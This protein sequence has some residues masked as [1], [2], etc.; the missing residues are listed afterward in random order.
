[1]WVIVFTQVPIVLL[2]SIAIHSLYSIYEYQT[3]TNRS[4]LRFVTVNT[5]IDIGCYTL[6]SIVCR[7]LAMVVYKLQWGYT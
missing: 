1:M 3:V 6:L 2:L 7:S 5:C 4:L